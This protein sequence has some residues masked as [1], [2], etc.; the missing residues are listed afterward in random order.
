MSLASISCVPRFPE[1]SALFR[2]VSGN[3]QQQ[4]ALF[5]AGSLSQ[6]SVRNE[7]SSVLPARQAPGGFLHLDRIQDSVLAKD[8]KKSA[9]EPICSFVR[10]ATSA[11]KWFLLCVI[12]QSGC[13]WTAESRTGTSAS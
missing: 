3:K 9:G 11:V 6:I 4:V 10:F 13:A 12:S 7:L 1:F 5:S 2:Q 8:R